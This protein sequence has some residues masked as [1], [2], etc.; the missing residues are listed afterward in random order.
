MLDVGLEVSGKSLVAYAVHER[1]QRVFE[2]ER[3]VSRA[4][5]RALRQAV[6]PAAS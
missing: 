2:G 1:T 5:L 6:G 3:P 4:G